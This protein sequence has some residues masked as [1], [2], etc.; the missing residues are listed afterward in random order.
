VPL[1]DARLVG[2]LLPAAALVDAP[3]SETMMVM[4]LVRLLIR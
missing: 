2:A 1:V 3:P 4:W